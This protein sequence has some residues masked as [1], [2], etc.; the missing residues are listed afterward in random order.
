VK[1]GAYHKIV[2]ES[3]YFTKSR[4]TVAIEKRKQPTRGNGA[5][6]S[7]RREKDTY[8]MVTSAPPKI[9]GEK[10]TANAGQRKLARS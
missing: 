3:A 4:R 6:P 8:L 2:E 7:A 5:T 10:R 9:L 1:G